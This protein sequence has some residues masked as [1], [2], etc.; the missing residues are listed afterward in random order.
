MARNVPKMVFGFNLCSSWALLGAPWGQKMQDVSMCFYV[1]AYSLLS[2]SDAQDDPKR[3]PRGPQEAP[4]RAQG[5]PTRAQ[6]E[7]KT[8]PGLPQDSS[9]TSPKQPKS[10]PRA[11]LTMPGPPSN[12][13]DCSGCSNMPPRGPQDAPRAPPKDLPAGPKRAS[14]GPPAGVNLRTFKPF[15]RA[16]TLNH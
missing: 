10:R 1:F 7:P 11:S 12:V 14:K 16:Q 8:A 3:A 9:K 6:E 15:P 5:R 13:Y 2:A 4:R